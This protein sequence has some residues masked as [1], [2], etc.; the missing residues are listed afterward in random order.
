MGSPPGIPIHGMLMEPLVPHF[1]VNS[2][3]LTNK[4]SAL[5]PELNPKE[6]PFNVLKKGII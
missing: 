3:V 2:F 5:N 4:T 1:A 6:K